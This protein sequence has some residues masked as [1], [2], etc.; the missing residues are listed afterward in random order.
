MRKG[1]EGFGFWIFVPL[2]LFLI[3]CSPIPLL[4]SDKIFFHPCATG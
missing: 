2:P 3:P 1:S 4:I